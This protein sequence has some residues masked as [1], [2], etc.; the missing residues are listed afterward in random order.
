MCIDGPTLWMA[1]CTM[2]RPH[3]QAKPTICS[4]YSTHRPPVDTQRQRELQILDEQINERIEKRKQQREQR[5][6]DAAAR[7]ARKKS[8]THLRDWITKLESRPGPR[9]LLLDADGNARRLTED[10]RQAQLADARQQIRAECVAT[11]QG[12]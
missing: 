6:Y 1:M 11:R 10:E 7:V 8:C 12:Q 3:T 2:T 5:R 9:I 4:R